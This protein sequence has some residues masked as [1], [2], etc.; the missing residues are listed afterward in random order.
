MDKFNVNKLFQ[1]L[2]NSDNKNKDNKNKEF[3]ECFDYLQNKFNDATLN[4]KTSIIVDD[5][6]NKKIYTHLNELEDRFEKNG[7][8]LNYSDYPLIEIIPSPLYKNVNNQDEIKKRKIKFNFV[9][10]SSLLTVSTIISYF[11]LDCIPFFNPFSHPI[12]FGLTTLIIMSIFGAVYSKF[13]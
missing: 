11:I 1:N 12:V 9:V 7:I 2:K 5:N 6:F 13:K 10:I 8:L 3:F 4:G